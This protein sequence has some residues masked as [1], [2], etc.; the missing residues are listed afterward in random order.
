MA[1][2]S[3]ALED[4]SHQFEPTEGGSVN[5]DDRLVQAVNFSGEAAESFRVLRSKILMPQDGRPAPK[6]IMVASVL[7]K[8]GKSFVCANLGI[9]LAQ[10]VDQYSLLVDCDLRLPSL[11]SI[12]GLQDHYGLADYLKNNTD[13]ATLI[14]KTSMEKLSVLTS[15][16]PPTNPAELLGS[17]R[18]HE[19]IG[20]LSSRY[21][22]RFVI[23]DSP[24]LKVASE[25]M[26]LA[27]VVDGVILVVRHGVSSRALIEQAIADIG[28][29]KL[30]GVVFN[31]HK[32]NFITSR[33][34]N[35]SYS[36]FGDY[37]R[38]NIPFNND[39]FTA[40]SRERLN[41][42]EKVKREG[43]GKANIPDN[44]TFPPPVNKTP[45]R[46]WMVWAVLGIIL[47]E[48]VVVAIYAHYRGWLQPIYQYFKGVLNI[49]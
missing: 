46:N 38:K 11:A 2:I 10:G 34:I 28:K 49:G 23:F 33:L 21:P 25:A 20:E 43:V 44:S 15:G 47:I 26:T 40:D 13:V 19:L 27:Q 42:G 48:G 1:R 4:G 37:Y 30:L 35:R 9:T 24:P 17:N 29:E 36:Y 14:Q 18:M 12:F 5:W 6:T 16:V 31:S 45:W 22:D 32:S 3:G 7:P 41:V 39:L 8:E